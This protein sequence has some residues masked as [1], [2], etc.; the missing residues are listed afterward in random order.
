[1]ESQ[2]NDLAGE[3]KELL[4]KNGEKIVVGDKVQFKLSTEHTRTAVKMRRS[5]LAGQT[6]YR[7]IHRSF[8]TSLISQYDAYLV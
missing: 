8:L 3:I 6:A 2:L 4:E 7:L 5:F 1:M